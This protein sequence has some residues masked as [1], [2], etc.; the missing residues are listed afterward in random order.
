M[1]EIQLQSILDHAVPKILDV[2]EEVLANIQEPNVLK[3]TLISKWGCD[4]SAGHSQYKQV[5]KEEGFSDEY[6]LL[7]LS[8]QYSCTL[9]ALTE[10]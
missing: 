5:F 1:A 8:Y 6:Y 10:N 2:Q 4:G 9:K 3:L 7:F